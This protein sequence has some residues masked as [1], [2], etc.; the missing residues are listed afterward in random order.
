MA[1]LKVNNSTVTDTKDIEE[2][3]TQRTQKN[4]YKSDH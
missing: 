4:D 2:D 3:E 1:P